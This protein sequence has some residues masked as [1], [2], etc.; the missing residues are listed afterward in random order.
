MF[1]SYSNDILIN[2]RLVEVG[3]FFEME[4]ISKEEW[5]DVIFIYV[6]DVW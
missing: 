6:M 4:N 1:V 2:I 5:I 3:M